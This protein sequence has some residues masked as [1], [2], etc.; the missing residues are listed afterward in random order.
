MEFQGFVKSDVFENLLYKGNKRYYVEDLTSRD[1]TLENT[2]P[3]ILTIF[4]KRIEKHAWGVFLVEVID[5]LVERTSKTIEDMENFKGGNWTNKKIFSLD[6]KTNHKALKNGM[7]LNCNN[8]ALHSCWLLQD[9]LKFFEIDTNDV[10]FIIHRS[11]SAE[12]KEVKEYVRRETKGK[13]ND[14]LL[15][16]CGKTNEEILQITNNIDNV[17]NKILSQGLYKTPSYVDFFLFDDLAGFYNYSKKTKQY[18]EKNLN[19]KD[20]SYYVK[21]LDILTEFYKKYLSK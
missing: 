1:F 6:E 16:V 20:R 7:F 12:P 21:A 4:D 8:T 15:N 5:Y 13:F 2:A 10:S 14:Y 11:H 18:L 3:Y 9:L 17:L 19:L